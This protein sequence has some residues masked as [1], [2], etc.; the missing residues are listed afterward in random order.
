MNKLMA[1]AYCLMG[2]GSVGLNVAQAQEIQGKVLS[3]PTFT[4]QLTPGGGLLIKN[5]KSTFAVNSNF[6]YPDMK[7][8]HWNALVAANVP[9]IGGEWKWNAA[10]KNGKF[11]IDGA[12]KF[13]HLQRKISLQTDHLVIDD[14]FTNTSKNDVAIAFD[15]KVMALQTPCEINISGVYKKSYFPYSPEAPAVN[16]TIF[17][18][19]E[20][21]SLGMVAV[22]DFY[23]LQLSLKREGN[24]GYFENRSFGLPPGDSYTFEWAL[25]PTQTGDYY[26]FINKVRRDDV[27]P[28]CIEGGLAFMPYNFPTN[29]QRD[30]VVQ[31]LK[32]RS[33]KIIILAGPYSGAP[34]LGGFSRY[35]NNM[36]VDYD[37]KTY[38]E[39]IKRAV[40]ILKSIDP[41]IKC[42]APFE[43]ALT[44]DQA[45]GQNTPIYADSIAIGADGKPLGYK[46]PADA[47]AR[48]TFL[49]TKGHSFIYYPTLTNSYNRFTRETIEKALKET[50]IDGIYF[51]ISTYATM[52][53]RWTYDRWD[54]RTVDMD[55]TNFTIKRK[56]ADLCKLSEDARAAIMKT[57][58]DYKK[59]NVIVANNM[60]V[61]SKVRALPV[62]HFAETTMDYGYMLSHFSTPIMLGWTPGYSPG[63]K[64]IGKTG[65]WWQDWK[66]D[67]D[68]F[69][70]IKD[71]LESGNLYYTYWAPPGQMYNS[72]LTRPT[73]LEHMF[74]ITVQKIGAGI[75]EGK[76]RIITL[77]SGKYS[78]GDNANAKAYF[79]NSDGKEISGKMQ[80]V[81]NVSGVT[82][83]DI[84]VPPGGAAVIENISGG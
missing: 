66:T 30:E 65:T 17:L 21:T 7:P 25:Y 18:A 38:L 50:G 32:D 45:P 49:D 70:D 82:T 64:A 27:P 10:Q 9:K 33:A 39:N 53:F 41:E 46:F 68:Y 2:L 60:P 83:F 76:E 61:A 13:Y 63:A 79:Y 44:P 75:I 67:A 35:L 72:N 4:A 42:I 71:K 3:A 62:M 16:P 22:D 6:S 37:E 34:W 55:L 78:W 84:E 28:V 80:M 14:T 51:D 40:D 24:T 12:G 58:L 19:G 81:K 29:E 23:R 57:I 20:N 36:P 56:K 69:D 52:G 31:W 74:P 15:N 73:I 54:H 1:C 47:E 8:D 11:Y 48:K 26:D 5:G 43:T 59:G 77:H